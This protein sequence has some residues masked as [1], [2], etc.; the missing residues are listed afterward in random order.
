ML[1]IKKI[2]DKDFVEVLAQYDC[3]VLHKPKS[4]GDNDSSCFF[5]CLS[6]PHP[7]YYKSPDL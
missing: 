3:Q 6:P 2:E 1:K 5:D 4:Y 7:S